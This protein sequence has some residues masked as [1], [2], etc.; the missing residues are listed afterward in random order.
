MTN[1]ISTLQAKNLMK[2]FGSRWVVNNVSIKIEPG[3]IVGLLGRNGAGKTTTFQMI[4]GLLKPDSGQVL[5][6]A[7][8]IS[9]TPSHKRARLGITYLPQESSVFLK[10]DVLTNLLMVLKEY[11]PSPEKQKSTARE[12]LEELGLTSLSSQPAYS[13][14]GGERRRLEICRALTLEPKFLLLDEPF[15]GIDPLTIRELQNIFHQLKE[16]EIGILLSDHNVRDTFAISDHAYIIDEGEL[17]VEGT[18]REVAAD[19]S[20]RLRFLGKDFKLGRER[21]YSSSLGKS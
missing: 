7:L 4:T 2:R 5:L 12:L 8:D 1:P 15:T 19:E 14:S 18:P 17:L 3:K 9:K 11:E 13:L 6:D 20:A 10:A 21:T 16:K